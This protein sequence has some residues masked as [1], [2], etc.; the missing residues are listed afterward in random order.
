MSSSL[1]DVSMGVSW[2]KRSDVEEK[3]TDLLVLFL[4][5]KEKVQT[6]RK[7]RKMMQSQGTGEIKTCLPKDGRWREIKNV[8]S[9]SSLYLVALCHTPPRFPR[10][11]H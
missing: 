3:G 11:L 1:P 7:V 9:S 5:G 2:T 8:P 6:R 4:I 10:E